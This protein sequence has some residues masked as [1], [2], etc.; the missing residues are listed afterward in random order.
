MTMM[1]DGGSSKSCTLSLSLFSRIS[2]VSPSFFP[3]LS[4]VPGGWDARAMCERRDY[5][6]YLPA[7]LLGAE[8]GTDAG[9]A[10]LARFR[11]ALASFQGWHAFHNFTSRRAYRLDARESA[12]RRRAGPGRRREGKAGTSSSS[13]VD[14]EEEEEEDGEGDGA[15][16]AVAAPPAPASPHDGP[17]LISPTFWPHPG[18]PGDAIGPAHYRRVDVA[19]AADPAPLSPG[20]PPVVEV[21]LEGGSFML[22]QLRHMVGAAVGVSRGVLPAA[23]PTA[24]LRPGAR[25]TLPLAPPHTLLL[26]GAT[27][28]AFPRQATAADGGGPPWVG[29]RPRLDGPAA[30]AAVAAFRATTLLPALSS[31]CDVRGGP[32]A[33]EWAWW[34]RT[35]GRY[36]FDASEMDAFLTAAGADAAEAAA[37]AEEGAGG[38]ERQQPRR[39]RKGGRGG[40]WRGPDQERV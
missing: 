38:K 30:A 12:G 21:R 13:S 22:K 36:H 29:D 33:E 19:A 26:G 17:L 3:P 8:A 37:R 1:R 16:A 7:A 15:D 31:L 4:R 10:A 28:G 35:L 34:D 20:G 9:D 6:Y 40:K 39:E 24:A 14:G 18:P 2:H 5:M 11:A 27:F 32:V 23:Y 25:A